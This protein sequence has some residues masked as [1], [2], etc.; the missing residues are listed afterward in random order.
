MTIMSVATDHGERVL[1]PLTSQRETQA[2]SLA[3]LSTF[4]LE[5]T[6]KATSTLFPITAISPLAPPPSIPH[7]AHTLFS[8]K[9]LQSI[10]PTASK[11]AWRDA[12]DELRAIAVSE[13]AVQAM[14]QI[15]SNGDV[16]ASQEQTEDGLKGY[17]EMADWITCGVERAMKAWRRNVGDL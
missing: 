3:R 17:E 9:S 14:S 12:S 4:L 5:E 11:T 8:S 15:Q 2:E 1:I 16:L 13:Y 7:V 10:L 6:T